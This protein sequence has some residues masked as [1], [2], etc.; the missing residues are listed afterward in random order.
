ML[1]GSD[2][3][4]KILTGVEKELDD[5]RKERA[6]DRAWIEA[7]ETK[8]KDE[9]TARNSAAYKQTMIDF[10][11]NTVTP[12]LSQ[13][14]EKFKH[15]LA[16]FGDDTGMKITQA[17]VDDAD[18]NGGK[19][20]LYTAKLLELETY[21]A[22][23]ADK[24][25][26]KPITAIPPKEEIAPEKSDTPEIKAK[27]FD[28]T[29][30]LWGHSLKAKPTVSEATKPAEPKKIGTWQQRQDDIKL[31]AARLALLRKR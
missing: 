5:L 1:A 16:M 4:P 12:Y 26:P 21:L 17:M 6:K 23:I 13:N 22:S 27:P 31:N 18:S 9:E 29:S 19:L 10:A 7:Q 25:A 28:S 15:T 20:P 30:Q 3:P 24:I 2:A 11:A 14:G 8:A